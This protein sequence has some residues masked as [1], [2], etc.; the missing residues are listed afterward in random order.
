M[1]TIEKRR[2]EVRNTRAATLATLPVALVVFVFAWGAAAGQAEPSNV[3]NETCLD[4]HEGYDASLART[5]HTLSA[6]ARTGVACVSCHDGGEVHIDDPTV[7]N[8]SN[9]SHLPAAQTELTC[10]ECHVAHPGLRLIGHDPHAGLDMSCTSCHSVHAP[11]A[12][13]SN[14]G[15]LMC[16]NCH[17]AVAHQFQQRS[18]HPMMTGNLNCVSCHGFLGETEPQLGHGPAANCYSCHPDQSGP[19]LFEHEATSSFSPEGEGCVACHTPHGSVNDRL[20]VQQDDNLCRQC[21][22]IPAGHLTAH[23]GG[24]RGIACVDC[25]SDFHGSYDNLYLLD[26][27]LGT[28]FG[29]ESDACFCHFYR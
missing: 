14:A 20:L 15:T 9:P 18:N 3:D 1:I 24:F 19:Y 27:Q 16:A 4:C 26:P 7:D 28:K 17:T 8:I 23:E 2:C 29:R 25:H 13:P 5:G 21:H 11:A 22:G 6:S 10:T 12:G